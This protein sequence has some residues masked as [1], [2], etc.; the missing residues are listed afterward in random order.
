M[1]PPSSVPIK[2]VTLLATPCSNMVGHR[3]FGISCC[4]HP[5]RHKNLKS[6][7]QSL[8][9]KFF[10]DKSYCG[11]TSTEILPTFQIVN[12]QPSQD[13]SI[14]ETD[15]HTYPVNDYGHYQ[16]EV[17]NVFN[18]KWYKIQAELLTYFN[19]HEFS[20]IWPTSL[21]LNSKLHWWKRITKDWIKGSL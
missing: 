8:S 21:P 16:G 9:S 3:R 6:H 12:Q 13:A 14:G 11:V 17:L 7:T 15:Q 5:H 4:L 19:S 18:R 2:V 1:L 20:M 10:V